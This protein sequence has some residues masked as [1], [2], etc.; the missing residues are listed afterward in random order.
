MG[1]TPPPF[2]QNVQKKDQKKLPQ[3]FWIR[4]GPPP[5]FGQCPK[6][7]S[8]FLKEYFPNLIKF[9]SIKHDNVTH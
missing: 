2:L 4:V 8:F 6:G 1:S 3:N 7:S 5:P 9:G